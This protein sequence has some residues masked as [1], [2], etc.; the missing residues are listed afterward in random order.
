MKEKELRAHLTC[1][2]CNAVVTHTGLPLFW[3]LKVARF[4]L[5]AHAVQRQHGLALHLGSAALAGIMGPDEDLAKPVM[6]EVTLTACEGCV[7]DKLSLLAH[8]AM[9]QEQPTEEVPA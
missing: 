9:M 5:D 1:N 6:E 8:V 2:F 7:M 4:G 3:R